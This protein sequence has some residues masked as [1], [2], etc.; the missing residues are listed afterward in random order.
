MGILEKIEAR[1]TKTGLKHPRDPVLAA[2]F[3]GGNVSAAGVSVTADTA[4]TH[5]AVFA[6]VRVLAETMAQLP[7]H[8]YR[9]LA[10]GGKERA[11]DHPLYDKLHNAPNL[12]HTSYEWRELQ[13]GHCAL[14]GNAYA[15]ITTLN[16]GRVDQ[17]IPL[18][19]DRVMPF[20]APDGSVA[21]RYTPEKGGNVILLANEIMRLPGL[22]CNGIEG[23][24]P[25]TAHRETI[26]HGLAAREYGS[27]F[28]SNNA[29]PKG[30][31][32]VPAALDDAAIKALRASWDARHKG[33]EN[34][35]QLAIFD[36]GMEWVSIGIS[37][38]DAQYIEDMRMNVE[39]V[40]GIFRVPLILLQRTEKATSWGTG[41]EQFMLAFIIHTIMPWVV[42]WEQRM[43]LSLLSETD[44]QQY[45]IGFEL[46]GLLRGDAAARTTLYQ[47]MFNMG[48]L[49]ANDILR[50]EDMNPST[51]G[52]RK[53]VPLNMVPVDLVDK[54]L[55]KNNPVQQRGNGKDHY[56]DAEHESTGTPI[57]RA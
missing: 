20:E 38:E 15:Q 34:Q 7:L 29:A 3:G 30:G 12:K 22:S 23:L 17:I 1:A 21:I 6:C 28:F 2:W 53:Y 37:N 52:D 14:R 39:Q 32:R 16:N 57:H 49:S 36:A 4:I 41:I 8:V 26:G 45:F 46:K 44:R 40:A 56:E 47:A 50:L 10:D 43:N 19:P 11:T 35:H 27:R 54:V 5:D 9:R 42:R 13:T 24:S 25:I 31:I 51:D 33:L 18:H 55:L 48:A